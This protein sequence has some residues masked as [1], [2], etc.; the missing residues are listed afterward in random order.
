MAKESTHINNEASILDRLLDDEP[1]AGREAVPKMSCTL[2]ELRINVKRD[3]ESLLNTRRE[4][5]D[6]V[7]NESEIARSI[8]AYGLPDLT[9]FSMTSDDDRNQVQAEIE[10]AIAAFE[11]RLANVHVRLRPARDADR[12]LHFEIDAYLRARPAP[13]HVVYDAVLEPVTQ[14]CEVA[15]I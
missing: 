3:L 9:A 7:P 1:D 11:P 5:L 14:E 6:E 8:L 2:R 4:R 15:E 13:Q 10:R 12:R